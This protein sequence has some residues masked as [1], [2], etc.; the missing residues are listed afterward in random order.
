MWKSIAVAVFILI[1]CLVPSQDLQKIDFLSFS[2]QDLVVHFIMF[3]TF[4]F[5]LSL[6]FKRNSKIK[7]SSKNLIYKII[8]I[9]LGFALTTEFLQL[10]L[11]F[12]NR[13]VNIGDLILDFAGSLS[14]ITASGFIKK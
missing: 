4:A 1:L 3:F 14:G 2:Y 7:Y 11:P 8:L 6:D 9:A 12:L 10:I 5:V 13:S